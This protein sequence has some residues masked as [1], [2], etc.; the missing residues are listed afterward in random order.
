MGRLNLS[1]ARRVTARSSASLRSVDL[2]IGSSEHAVIP[3]F[4]LVSASGPPRHIGVVVPV[5]DEEDLLADC[6]DAVALAADRARAECAVSVGVVVV[7]DSCTDRSSEIAGQ[8]AG[9]RPGCRTVTVAARSVGTARAVGMAAHLHR[10]DPARLWLAT[11]DADSR[12]PTDWLTRQLAH[13][14]AGADA[15]LGT[16][17]VEDWSAHLP[18]VSARHL[19]R[20]TDRAGHRHVHGANLGLTAQAYLAAGGFAAVPAHEDVL[21]V[22][23][24]QEA[25]CELAWVDDLPVITSARPL[26]RA[27]LGFARYLRE[28]ACEHAP[29]ASRT[30][31]ADVLPG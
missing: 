8:F 6:L 27:P 18:V 31:S 1:R 10:R 14:A 30:E 28:L 26:G 7:L 4:G 23:A 22:Q 13:H 15:V 21:L 12:V 24:L 11:T 17:R 2:L 9:D 5:H 19:S 16:V 3:T 29:L 25:G 20:Y